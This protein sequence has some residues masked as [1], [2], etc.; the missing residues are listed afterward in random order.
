MNRLWLLI[1]ILL[2]TLVSNTAIAGKPVK[3]IPITQEISDVDVNSVPYYIQSDG[4]GIYTHT[5][6]TSRGKTTGTNSVL[7][8]NVCGGLTYGDRLLETTTDSRKVKVTLDQT[9]AIQPGDPNYVVPA[10][11]FGTITSTVRFMNKCT[12]GAGQNMYTM[13]ADTEIYCPMHIRMNSVNYRLDMGTAGE[14]ET[15]FVR[16]YCIAADSAGCKEWT[17]DPISDPG[18]T[19]NPGRTR[20]R[21]VD[22]NTNENLGNYYMTFHLHVLR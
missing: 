12:C 6:A 14:T 2:L 22:L 8:T 1:S 10:Q 11:F 21:L 9:N 17:L 15:E 13:P 4:L 16:I 5:L 7:M 18:D 20:A 3:D 19:T